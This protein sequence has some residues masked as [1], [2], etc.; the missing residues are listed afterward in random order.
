MKCP[1][2][3]ELPPAPVGRRGWPWTDGSATLPE[4][5]PDGAPWP[6]ISIVTPSLNQALFIEETIRSV[7]LQGYPDLEYVIV[8]GGST[9]ESV[10]IIRKYARWLTAWVSEQ[11]RGQSH[12]INKGFAEVAGD[13]IA[14]LNSDDYY[15]PNALS[16]IAEAAA[17]SPGSVAW[18]GSMAVVDEQGRYQYTYAPR[19]GTKAEV[20][21]WHV[22]AFIPQP[23]CLL[24]AQ[25]IREIGGPKEPYHFMMDM[26]LCMRLV[27]AGSMTVVPAT[28]ASIRVYSGTKTSQHY[29]EGLIEM[30]SANFENDQPEVARTVLTRHVNAEIGLALDRLTGADVEDVLNRLPF[31]FA[32]SYVLKRM[33]HKLR[34]LCGAGRSVRGAHCTHQRDG[35]TATDQPGSGA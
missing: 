35:R 12:A 7:L 10:A 14:W 3:A 19:V 8:D 20:G 6:R 28:L 11:D 27:S 1:S 9:D 13:V 30:L 21:N 18:V 22:D 32:A 4:R 33:W 24:N 16:K 26:E 2:L 15:M 23:S 5:M 31:A 29:T 17:A 34:R 25:V